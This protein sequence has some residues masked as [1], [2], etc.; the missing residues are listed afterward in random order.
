MQSKSKPLDDLSNLLTN[1]AGAIK[2]VGDEMR[3]MGRSQAD[4]IIS[5]MDL[6]SRDEFEVLKEMFTASQVEITALKKKISSL[7]KQVKALKK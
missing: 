4:K 7:E 3:A 1:A 5:E 2:G 6:I